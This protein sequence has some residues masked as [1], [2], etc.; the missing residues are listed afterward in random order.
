M[1]AWLDLS[2]P[3]CAVTGE[4]PSKLNSW[5]KSMESMDTPDSQRVMLDQHAH[6]SQYRQTT[7]T[8]PYSTEKDK[9]QVFNSII[10]LKRQQVT[11]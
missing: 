6:S 2:L 4:V 10:F 11:F 7:W 3:I 5:K 9:E 8:E 1:F